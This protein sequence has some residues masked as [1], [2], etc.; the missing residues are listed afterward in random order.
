MGNRCYVILISSFLFLISCDNNYTPKP[1]GYYRIDLPEKSYKEFF[2]D[3]CPYKFHYPTYT[4]ISNHKSPKNESCWYDIVYPKYNAQIHLSYKNVDDGFGLDTLMEDSRSF[5][6]KHTVKADAIDEILINTKNDV[7][8]IIYEIGGN[9]A[10]SIQFFV[11]DSTTHF[12]R[13]AFYFKM[14]PNVDSLAPV[15]SFIRE[16]LLH[17]IN[18]LEWV[19]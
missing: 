6:Y 8:G 15:I 2:V 14:E 12:L 7:H 5:V 11:T 17:L 16:D 18:T 3:S 9:T 13:G 10:S 1:K 4:V 19:E